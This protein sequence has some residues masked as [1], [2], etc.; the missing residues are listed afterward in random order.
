MP[1]FDSL[2]GTIEM[3]ASPSQLSDWLIGHGRHFISTAEVAEIYDINPASVPAG[4]ERARGA[5]KLISRLVTAESV[6]LL[7]S[8]MSRSLASLRMSA[9]P[10]AHSRATCPPFGVPEVITARCSLSRSSCRTA[11]G[12][13]LRA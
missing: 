10:S 1:D 9:T 3:D 6:T 4:L 2:G 11:Q 8:P 5:G 12:L 13:A 7:R